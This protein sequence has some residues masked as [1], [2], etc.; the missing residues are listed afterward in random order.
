MRIK[1]HGSSFSGFGGG[2]RQSERSERFRKAYRAGQKVRGT[3][4]EWRSPGLAWVEIA[5]HRLLAQ[6][7]A[8]ATLGRERLFL[9]E[10]LSPEI[11]LRELPG[12]AREGLDVLV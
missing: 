1:G 5:G 12:G 11:V 9:I 8:D 4:A 7:A 3:I 10:R 2:E 6:V